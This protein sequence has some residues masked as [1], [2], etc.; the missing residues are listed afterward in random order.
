MENTALYAGLN[1]DEVIASRKQHGSNGLLLTEDR[2]LF[3]VIK[4]VVFEPM[5]VLLVAACAIYFL[6]QQN[7]EG[8]IMLVSIFIVAGISFYQQF[9]SRSAVLALK[10]ISASKATVVRNNQ[11]IQINMDDLVV[12]DVLVMEEGSVL[13][14]DGTVLE[15]NDFS[16]NE[17]IL[18]G[19]AMSVFKY[20]PESDP[21][22]RGTLVTT[23]MAHIKITAVGMQTKFAAIGVSLQN[24]EVQQTPLQ[25]QIKSFVKYMAW[26]GAAAFLL[27]FGFNY[28]TSGS[29]TFGLLQGLTLAMSVLP[30]EI[31]VAFSAFMA[32]GAF[33]LMKNK[34][35]VKQPQ[36]VETLGSA[37]VICV[38]KTGTL[39]ENKMQIAAIYDGT[40]LQGYP[41]DAL[42]QA[43]FNVV[44]YAMWASETNPFDP[45]ETAIVKL[46]E[47]QGTQNKRSQYQ[48]VHEYPLSGK[49]PVMTH[50]F[51]NAAG[52]MI[53]ASK[54]APEGI[55][56]Q[57]ALNN[58]TKQAI[59]QQVDRYAQLGYRVLAVASSNFKGHD[60]PNSQQQFAFSF[61]GLVAF[62]DPPKNGMAN[63]IDVFKKAGVQVKMI[64]GDHAATALNIAAAIGLSNNKTVLTGSE[65]NQLSKHELQQKVQ[66]INVFARMFPEVKLKV[67]EALKA[68]GEVVAMT[69][70]GVNDAPALKAAQIGIAMGRIGSDVA[71]GAA[72]LI[73]TDDNLFHMTEAIAMGRKIY[74]NLQKAIQYIVSI[75]IPIIL[76]VTMPLVFMWKFTNIFSPVHVIFLELIMGPT[77]SI[78]Y[79]NEQMEKGTMQ[80]PPRKF[81]SNFLSLK[82]LLLSIAQ[83]LV[84]AA[85]CL[86]FGYYI[87]QNNNNETGR[88]AI[89]ITLL[90]SNIFLTLINRSFY[91]SV[92]T[93]LGS[94]NNLIWIVVAVTL[95]LIATALYVPFVRQLFQLTYLP[96][97][98]LVQCIVVA[99][100]C[101]GWVEV[102]KWYKRK[103]P[104]A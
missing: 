69:G 6:L 40:T 95:V 101:T 58:D 93:M 102:Y 33:R 53:V 49:P 65:V 66:Q 9:K 91:Y 35:I 22:F 55:L 30:E 82:Q 79:E 10:K 25:H 39:T 36:F 54:G 80:R 76:I 94:K 44:E 62:N 29:F 31:P 92:F 12:N 73:I 86:V 77:C 20:A 3:R 78:I 13:P 84:I 37:T 57:C 89:F 5:F 26:F 43:V 71:K 21:V 18:T 61:V 88:S 50:L 41:F 1:T 11:T 19:E 34:V 46:Y 8:F 87:L 32:L 15:A 81:T 75:H 28:Y 2:V 60:Y 103:Q 56:A 59:L 63:T 17:A 104:K 45:M 67:I 23:G 47:K 64:T 14:A 27:V 7:R 96:A 98:G 52:K 74:D 38:D 70:D 51:E 90:F 16:V 48:Q 68:N 42:P 24:I 99:I 85:G 4:E 72:S 100:V 83:G 97:K